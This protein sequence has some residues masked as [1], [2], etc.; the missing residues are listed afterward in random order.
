MKTVWDEI[1][2]TLVQLYSLPHNRIQLQ[3]RNTTPQEEAKKKVTETKSG[4]VSVS[5]EDYVGPKVFL[6]V[7]GPSNRAY[8]GE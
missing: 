5:R 2:E 1:E 4:I 7:V 8:S 3:D 6:R